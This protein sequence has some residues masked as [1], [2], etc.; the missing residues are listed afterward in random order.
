MNN[1]RVSFNSSPP[2]AECFDTH[3][4]ERRIPN[5]TG[6]A[7][8]FGDEE[9]IAERIFFGVTHLRFPPLLSLDLDTTSSSPAFVLSVKDSKKH[10]M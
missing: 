5:T 10:T 2:S 6:I 7:R 9:R 8:G 4:I 1:K 3:V